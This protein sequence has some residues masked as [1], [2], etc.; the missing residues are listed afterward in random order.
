VVEAKEKAKKDAYEKALAVYS[1]AVKAFRK[2]DCQK[3]KEYF[4]SLQDKHPVERE[5][6]DRAKIY[7]AICENRQKKD[8][9]PLK[10]FEDYFL[11]AVYKINQEDF[12]EAVKLLEK[13]RAKEPKEGKAVYLMALAYCQMGEVD[14]CL[15]SLKEAVHL[16][17]FFG[18]LAR[19]E[20][21]F[22]P[23]WEDRKFKVITKMA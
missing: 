10:T 15:E 18:I 8:T 13:A 3:V 20:L 9:I 23:I 12:A 7:L 14:K 1:Q 2:N 4:K 19:N 11:Y 6:V 5:L 16:D 21:N 17:K 22:E